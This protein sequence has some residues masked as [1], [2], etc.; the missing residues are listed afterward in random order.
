[1]THAKRAHSLYG[2]SSMARVI[3]CPGSVALIKALPA[4][5]PSSTY[6]DEGTRAHEM[7]EEILRGNN[8]PQR[9]LSEL[10]EESDRDALLRYVTVVN[11]HRERI[12]RR[13]HLYVEYGFE[14]RDLH[15]TAHG[16][17]DAAV[18]DPAERHAM[19]FD[20]K[21]GKGK[22][23]KAVDNVQLMTYGCGLAI[24][25][26]RNGNRVDRCSLVIVQPRVANPIRETGRTIEGLIDYLISTLQ[27]AVAASERPDAPLRDGPECWFCPVRQMDACPLHKARRDAEAKQ[28][29]DAIEW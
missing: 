3:Q 19:L 17:V 7:A 26:I 25:L 5:P 29:M 28:G 27:P 21:W 18:Y 24:D 22:Q 9:V 16:T 14:F 1:M 12:G 11:S 6:A 13:A 15:S 20:L 23:V 4:Q 8:P 2:G 10:T